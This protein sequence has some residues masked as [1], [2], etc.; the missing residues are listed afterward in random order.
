MR[1][2]KS[3]AKVAISAVIVRRN[4]EFAGVARLVRPGSRDAL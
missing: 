1:A 3:S 2:A 4:P